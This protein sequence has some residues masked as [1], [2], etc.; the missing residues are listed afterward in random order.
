MDLY[1]R[2]EKLLLE[3]DRW[4]DNLLVTHR[5]VINMIYYILND[6]KPTMYKDEFKVTHS[7]VHKLDLS[8]NKIEKIY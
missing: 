3:I 2:V 5:G 4:D 7:S 8:K 6:I 1:F